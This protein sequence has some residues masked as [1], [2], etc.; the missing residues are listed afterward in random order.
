[1]FSDDSVLVIVCVSR[2][3]SS[4]LFIIVFIIW[5]CFFGCVSVVVN[6]I[7]IC[8]IIENRLVIVVFIIS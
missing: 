6:G 7:S 1:M 2:M 3:F 4:S 5:L 8:V